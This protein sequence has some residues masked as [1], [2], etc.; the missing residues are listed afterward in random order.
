[1]RPKSARVRSTICVRSERLAAEAAHLLGGALGAL[2]VELGHHD[3]GAE[4][5]Q[6]QRGGAADAL[7]AAG[8]DGDAT[9][10]LGAVEWTHGAGVYPGSRDGML[11]AR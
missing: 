5:R 11:D 2:G 9:G 6:L 8:D 7:A 3:V 10:E 1:M 4:A